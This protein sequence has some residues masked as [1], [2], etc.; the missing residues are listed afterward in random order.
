MS[1]LANR[2]S[3]S[4]VAHLLGFDKFFLF[5]DFFLNSEDIGDCFL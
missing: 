3:G 1:D 5:F 2:Q 4:R